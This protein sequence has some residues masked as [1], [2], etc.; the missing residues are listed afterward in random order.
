[1]LKPAGGFSIIELMV[2][3]AMLALLL[4]LATP[5]FTLW[6]RNAQTRTVS[7]ALQTGLRLAQTE[8]ARRYRQVVF[9]RTASTSCNNSITASAS[10]PYWAVR[11]VPLVAGEAVQT[12]QCGAFAEV[13]G[14]VAI[15][16]PTALCFNS[17]GR[18]VANANP[19]VGGAACTLDASGTSQYNLSVANGDRP[20]RVLVTLGGSVRLC[21]PART[22]SASTPEGCP[23]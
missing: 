19:G 1:M 7:E 18:L 10:G 5:S 11:T 4:G 3:V 23:A 21:D 8:S 9:F 20:L 6:T 13:A 14:G 15:T 16:G 2:A 12:L 22:R 17:A